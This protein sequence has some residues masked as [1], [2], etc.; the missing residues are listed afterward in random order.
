MLKGALAL[1]SEECVGSLLEVRGR[2]DISKK[3][4]SIAAAGRVVYTDRQSGLVVVI[5][6]DSAVRLCSDPDF[7]CYLSE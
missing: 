1:A 6:L 3:S 5:N 2:R 7:A 4:N